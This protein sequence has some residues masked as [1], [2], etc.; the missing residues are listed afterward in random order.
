MFWRRVLNSRKEI[1][2]EK[3]KLER[4]KTKYQVVHFCTLVVSVG[5]TAGFLVTGEFGDPPM[6]TLC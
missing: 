4:R 6:K 1:V 3:T 5:N 2:K